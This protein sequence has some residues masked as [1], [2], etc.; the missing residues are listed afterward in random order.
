MRRIIVFLLFLVF[1]VGS[2]LLGK[3]HGI[4]NRPVKVVTQ[5]EQHKELSSAKLWEIVND[6]RASKGLKAYT[7]DRSLCEIASIR[8]H[9]VQTEWDHDIKGRFFKSTSFN[10]IGENLAKGHYPE[11]AVLSGWLSSKSHRENL[12]RTLFTHSCIMTDDLYA[13]QIFGSY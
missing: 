5:V 10:Y 11:S 8:V 6:W 2:Y 13:V 1:C 4:Q 3:T 7:E 12:E 9:E